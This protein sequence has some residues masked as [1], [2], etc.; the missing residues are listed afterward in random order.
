LCGTTGGC[1]CR[2]QGDLRNPGRD[3]CTQPELNGHSLTTFC[4]PHTINFVYDQ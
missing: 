1:S 2:V 3:G 4:P